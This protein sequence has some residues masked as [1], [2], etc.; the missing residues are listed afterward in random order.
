MKTLCVA[1]CICFCT[2]LQSQSVFGYWYGN[3]NL[4]LKSSTNNYLIEL[5][6]VPEKN[7]VKGFINYYF[8]D[9]YRSL[10]IKGNYQENKR[11]L[12][13]YNVPVAYHGSLANLEVECMM[14]MIGTLI[15]SR[16]GSELNGVFTGLPEYRYT[17]ADIRFNLKKAAGVNKVDSVLKAMSKFRE[18]VQIWKPK[19]A[20]TIATTNI[21]QRKLI[22]YVIEKQYTLRENLVAEVIE[23]ES[24]SIKV[25]FYDN[26]EIDGDSISVFFN[27]KLTA[28]HQRLNA[29]PVHFDLVLDSLQKENE[30]TMFA[31]NLGTIE[32]NTALMVIYDGRKKYNIRL[33]S[34]L[35]KN[36]TIKIRKKKTVR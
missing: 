25:D 13:L 10:A 8:K 17:C 20:D 3:A 1:L 33:S 21:I 22:N 30:L 29:R 35:E 31:E 5:V 14:N 11:Q 23:V 19:G 7:Y 12:N 27:K 32:P 9:T 28:F 15:A 18:S 26:G 34:N 6:L 16:S 4:N 36:A 24:D 2:S